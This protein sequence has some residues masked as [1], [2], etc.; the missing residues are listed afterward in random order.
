MIRNSARNTAPRYDTRAHRGIDPTRCSWNGACSAPR[1]SSDENDLSAAGS[2]VPPFRCLPRRER[3][4]KVI[5]KFRETRRRLM[6][7]RSP[8]VARRNLSALTAAPRDD[9][10]GFPIRRD[11]SG[12][13][14]ARGAENAGIVPQG[15]RQKKTVGD[16]GPFPPTYSAPR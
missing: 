6:N 1:H 10:K 13:V 8:R 2:F 9:K 14:Q 11:R 7:I 3:E 5:R 4:K 16:R 15:W 12:S